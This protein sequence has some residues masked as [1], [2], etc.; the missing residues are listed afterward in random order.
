M[1]IGSVYLY[2]EMTSEC[3]NV[4]SVGE[5][6]EHA[7]KELAIRFLPHPRQG[8]VTPAFG[9]SEPFTLCLSEAAISDNVC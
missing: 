9:Q 2:V 1:P 8:T 3:M 5:S 4:L 6:R 7:V